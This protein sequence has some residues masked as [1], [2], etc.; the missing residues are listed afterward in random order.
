MKVAVS[1]NNGLVAKRFSDSEEFKIYD[2]KKGKLLNSYIISTEGIK[3]SALAPFLCDNDV[4]VVFCNGIG[5]ESKKALAK[6]CIIF[7]PGV[8][9]KADHQIAAFLK[10]DLSFNGMLSCSSLGEDEE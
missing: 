4:D 10:G 7:F 9:G 2:V 6:E 8:V 1:Y 3:G 5:H